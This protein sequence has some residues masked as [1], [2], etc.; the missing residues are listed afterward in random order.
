MHRTPI[1]ARLN[2]QSLLSKFC[3]SFIGL[4]FTPFTLAALE[5]NM[6]PGVTEVSRDVYALHNTILWICVAIGVVVFG[7][8]F[9]AL[10]KH[11]KSKGAVPHPFHES[12]VV[13]IAWTVVPFLILIA[14]AIP[15]TKTL[16]HMYDA[17][18]A[19][20]NIKVTGYQWKWKYDYLD[21]GN[22]FGFFSNLSD[23]STKAM[24]NTGEF[25]DNYLLD[26]DNPM[27][28]PINKKVRIL[29]TANDVIHSW[30]IPAFGVKK[31]AVPGF[32]NETWF[33][34]EKP[35]VYRGQCT[36]LCGKGHG[37]MPVVVVAMEQQQYNDWVKEQVKLASQT[38][39]LSD[40]SLE[41]LMAEGEKVYAKVCA[42]CHMPNGQGLPGVFPALAGSAIANDQNSAEKHIEVV[43]NGVSGT[44]MQAFDEQLNDF[45]LAAVITYE[46]KSWGNNASAVQP[47]EVNAWR[48]Q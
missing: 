12:V 23:A 4:F 38:V 41:V 45:E 20:V 35:G 34:A 24:Y 5:Y 42:A 17:D 37:Y 11:R 29:V 27:V 10:I 3:I 44:A 9:Y 22:G 21:E 33:K 36:E 2:P 7:V 19:D 31:D 14:M 8:M 25:P 28:V 26:V 40:R 39:D 43:F 1:V 6:K 32:I 16:I 47:K 15:A 13:E 48:N 18:D 30:W 46:R